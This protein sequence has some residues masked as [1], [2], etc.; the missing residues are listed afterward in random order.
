MQDE[1]QAGQAVLVLFGS[2]EVS[3]E[4]AAVLSR[5]LFLAHKSGG[6]EVY[7]ATP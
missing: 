4:D 3:T 1:I 2:G 5:G 6:D 7:T